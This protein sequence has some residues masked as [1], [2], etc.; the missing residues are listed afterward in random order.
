MAAGPWF[1][2]LG[3]LD[4]RLDGRP[5][6]VRAGKHRA[7]LAALLLRAGRVV[8]IGELVSFLWG[9]APPAR[10]RG[11]LQTYVMRLRQLLGDPSLIR[12]TS[13]G[14]R[15]VVPRER[16]DAH[17]F[18]AVA[19]TASRA[20]REGNLAEA[21]D[22]YAEAVGLW[23]GPALA[24]VPSDALREEEVP[25]LTERLMLVHE[26]RT[27]VE[28]AL[29][30]HDR[31]V[32]VLRGL[33]ADHPLRERF[34]AQLMLALYRCSRQAEALEAF[35]RVD[36]VLAEQLGIEPGPELRLLHQRILAGDPGLAAP[37]RDAPDVPRQLPADVPAFVGREAEAERIVAL[38]APD[39]PRTAV[40]IVALTGPSGVGKT[41]LAVRVAH[42]LRDRF[43]DGQLYAD[44]RGCSSGPT[45]V[46][47]VLTGFLRALGV[48]PEQVPEDV[49]EQSS[50][51]RSLLAGRRMLLVLDDVAAPDQVRPLLPGVAGCP[52][53]V[54]SR[55]DLRGLIAVDGARRVALGVLSPD[56]SCALLGRTG[57]AARELARR[58]G[59][60]PLVL[61]VAAAAL[62]DGSVE[63]F[64]ERLGDTPV[65]AF[66]HAVLPPPARRLFGLLSVVPG[67]DFTVEA[68]ANTGDLAVVEAGLL[69][70][71]LVAARLVVPGGG[72][73]RFH[74]EVARLAASVVVDPG[75]ARTRLLDFY[76]AAVERCGA[77]L[78]PDSTRPPADGVRLPRVQTRAEARAWLDAERTN[79]VAAVR[80]AAERGPA[81][82]A[83][84]LVDGLRGYLWIG[85]H[86][87]EW[88]SA[89]RYGLDAAHEQQDLEGEAAMRHSL[90][91]LHW[92]LGDHRA[93]VAHY[94]AAVELHRGAGDAVAEADV[95]GHLG[96]VLLESGEPGAAR[97]ELEAC[98][99]LRREAGAPRLGDVPVLTALGAL[100]LE[101]GA[102]PEAVELLSEAV[103]T[104]VGHDPRGGAVTPR[105]LLA[106]ARH[107]S[108]DHVLDHLAET[109]RR[110][111]AEGFPEATAKV[112]ETTARVRLDL[113]DPLAALD[114]ATR[115]LA[116]LREDADQ[117]VTTDVLI[118]MAAANH[119]LTAHAKA[120]AQY[121]QALTKAR[122]ISYRAA[123]AKALAGLAEV[124]RATGN[125]GE[126]TTLAT[127][128]TTLAD[129]LGLPRHL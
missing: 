48:P 127:E 72:R 103:T 9:G 128:A 67:V 7:L 1:G 116:E 106:L 100:A 8:P 69:L 120:D 19:R 124:R 36:R 21:A 34:W 101:T 95:R 96:A 81:D 66:A 99:A 11:T 31:L 33:T 29:G 112:L 20:A 6:P 53:L 104:S 46:V 68:A 93:S 4:V 77:L 16:V 32:P 94:R 83:W 57:E 79:L 52:V 76:V 129:T 123:E 113:G 60:L 89:A 5:V 107:L 119:A 97:D 88:R 82:V 43:P 126:A 54:T 40:P 27:D 3:P 64:L 70:D 14:Y 118:V 35:R 50:L 45:P 39:G 47:A 111:R 108:G 61:G 18:T 51:F 44:L 87:V 22:L 26:E 55:D 25:R 42:R 49:D 13:D 74:D 110:S 41:A 15:M 75:P 28:L 65:L 23:R 125:P 17:R 91:A 10:T 105:T 78:H 71:A 85:K 73:Y 117:R 24:D 58:C 37:G 121:Q 114:L 59:G 62:G 115:A 86:V 109:L 80:S 122:R 98:L 30:N 56:E 38:V 102:L 90:G 84:R 92:R 2:L 12:T 63:R